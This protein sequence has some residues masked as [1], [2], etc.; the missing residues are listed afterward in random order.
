MRKIIYDY[1]LLYAIAHVSIYWNDGVKERY[2]SFCK[3]EWNQRG[4]LSHMVDKINK[5]DM[6]VTLW[7]H[8]LDAANRKLLMQYLLNESDGLA[9]VVE[10]FDV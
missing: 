9:D 1:R 3:D 6:P 7:M 4:I 8:D 5:R 10:E 2:I